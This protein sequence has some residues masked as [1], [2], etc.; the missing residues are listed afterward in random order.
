MR[1]VFWCS[2]AGGI[3]V[4]GGVFTVA[5]Y[6]A[7]NPQSFAG[8]AIL[9]AGR[10]VTEANPVTM[11]NA[12]IARLEKDQVEPADEESQV[13]SEEPAEPAEERE[14]CGEIVIPD[15]EPVRLCPEDPACEPLVQALVQ[16][17]HD[18]AVECPAG[19]PTECPL[20][21]PLCDEEACEKLG[22]PCSEGD[23]EE[24]EEA[25]VGS[26]GAVEKLFRLFEKAVKKSEE[27]AIDP[28]APVS[29]APEC[30][31]DCHQHHHYSGC[32]YTGHGS[33][34]C[35]TGSYQPPMPATQPAPLTQPGA[36]EASE[37]GKPE[38][39]SS[40]L[41]AIRRFST[42]SVEEA[43]PPAAIDTMEYR[44][45]DGQLYDYGPGSM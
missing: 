15:G 18:D 14:V 6:A 44:T 31:Q 41:E 40:A 36:E 17:A 7:R 12:A 43:V 26:T 4:L 8:R 32:P 13:G 20:T 25:G 37:P 9:S 24:Q 10:V 2:L 27:G 29:Q 23:V 5:F 22:M 38:Q 39:H 1:K 3:M 34:Y 19:G 42:R 11:L 21:M 33:M 30:R 35:P 45:A 16:I 28:A